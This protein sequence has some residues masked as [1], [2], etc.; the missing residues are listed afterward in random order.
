MEALLSFLRART[1][2]GWRGA[3]AAGA[4]SA[5]RTW[6]ARPDGV[7][8]VDGAAVAS[9]PGEDARV[10]RARSEHIA[11]YDPAHVLKA[12]E[13]I[14]RVIEQYELVEAELVEH[15]ERESVLREYQDLV[16]PLLALP[17][18]DHPDYRKEWSPKETNALRSAMS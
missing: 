2:E 9:T 1:D 7:E 10:D 3:L 18:S 11:R 15:P 16:L 14:R 8:S 6:S 12:L 17:F 4:S 5:E 13:S